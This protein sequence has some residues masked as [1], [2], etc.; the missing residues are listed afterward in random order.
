MIGLLRRMFA[1]RQP[2]PALRRLQLVHAARVAKVAPAVERAVVVAETVVADSNEDLMRA[3]FGRGE[4]RL[5][6]R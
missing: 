1:S 2:D 4:R 5:G 6:G 3:S